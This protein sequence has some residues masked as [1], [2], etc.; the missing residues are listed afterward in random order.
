MKSSIVSVFL[1]F[2]FLT[3]LLSGCAPASTLIPSA[4]TATSTLI[5]PTNTSVPTATAPPPTATP[6]PEPAL[7]TVSRNGVVTQ[8]SLAGDTRNI[9]DGITGYSIQ[10]L[11]YEF[12]TCA[13]GQSEIVVY[14]LDSNLLRTMPMPPD[15]YCREFTVL[16]DGRIAVLSNYD[17]KVFFIDSTGKLL[18]TAN[19]LDAKDD[20]GQNLSAVVVD[21][22]LVLSE[23]GKKHVLAFDLNTYERLIFKDFS[24]LPGA[25]LGAITYDDGAFYLATADTIYK[26]TDTTDATIVAKLP[27]GNITSIT[28]LDGVAYVS[29]NF[30]GEIYKV[31]TSDGTI[32]VFLTGLDFPNDLVL[33]E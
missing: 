1:T 17:D 5:P 27:E 19:I 3:V 13:Q 14:D 2:V 10:I 23:D 16:P 4:A 20:Q 29:V 18:A 26:F 6:K 24:G 31:N 9:L 33:S 21:N 12:Y 15:V 25:W 28:I 8:I 22:R 7:Y 30:T 32:S 11:A